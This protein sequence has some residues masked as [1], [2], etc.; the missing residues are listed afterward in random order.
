MIA[1][2]EEA[3]CLADQIR[4]VV[5]GDGTKGVVGFEDASVGIGD[6]DDGMQV[7]GL[8]QALQAVQRGGEFGIL[9]EQRCLGGEPCPIDFF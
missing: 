5:A 7:E 1:G 6:G 8:A 3:R 2:V 9:L 4:A